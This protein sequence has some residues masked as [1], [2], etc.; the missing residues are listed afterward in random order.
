MNI[1]SDYQDNEDLSPENVMNE[2][3]NFIF[4]K[5]IDPMKEK[6]NEDDLALISIIGVSFKMI[7]EQAGAY[8]KT[9]SQEYKESPYIRN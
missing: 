7:A 8:E 3:M 4:Q 6:L 1:N 9:Q 2:G 5:L